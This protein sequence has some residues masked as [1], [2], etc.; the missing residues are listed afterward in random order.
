MPCCA[1]PKFEPVEELGHV[2]GV[3]C[4]LVQCASCGAFLL[5]QWS[6]YAPTKTFYDRL[7]LEEATGFRQ[8]QGRERKELLR[9]WYNKH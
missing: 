4:D 5:Q 8:S 1:N 7:T 3:D 2:E 9:D 6:V